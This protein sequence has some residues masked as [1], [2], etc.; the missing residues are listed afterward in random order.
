MIHTERIVSLTL[1]ILSLLTG[2]DYIVVK[3]QSKE[4]A[5]T[6]RLPTPDGDDK[7]QSHKPDPPGSS[8]IPKQNPREKGL[9][10]AGPEVVLRWDDAA[11]YL[12]VEEWEYL[13]GHKEQYQQAVME[14]CQPAG[15]VGCDTGNPT[16]QQSKRDRELK[17]E[18]QE[19]RIHPGCDTAN[20]TPRR[21]KRDTEPKPEPQEE[22][23]HP[24]TPLV[25]EIQTD[26]PHINPSHEYL[27]IVTVM[28]TDQKES[29][30][31]CPSPDRKKDDAMKDRSLEKETCFRV[32]PRRHRRGKYRPTGN[33][34]VGRA[35]EN[36]IYEFKIQSDV[37]C[38]PS[39]GNLN[40][41]SSAPQGNRPKISAVIT[42]QKQTDAKCGKEISK[43]YS[44]RLGPDNERQFV[45]S[46]CGKCFRSYCYISRHIRSHTGEKPFQ[47]PVC[48]K[49]FSDKSVLIRHHKSHTGQRPFTC[50]YC[51]KC[52]SHRAGLLEHLSLHAGD[53]PYVCPECGKCFK[54]RA[55]LTSHRRIHR[56][57][58]ICV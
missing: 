31:E 45:C 6:S 56:G 15:S 43:H 48:S 50:S 36:P 20:P 39:D 23:I 49:C 12:S 51:E 8:L 25:S 55:S 54:Y 22:R 29:L 17:L 2:E 16:P 5:A 27:N 18:P 1:E 4:G 7:S 47:C 24:D 34:G 11:V 58:S 46:F 38:L 10:P 32:S 13:K 3:K 28:E 42:S 37:N 53:R 41:G 40:R 26:G 30:A 21:S 52:F 9:E 33:P 44:Q 19:E 35:P 57:K 14:D